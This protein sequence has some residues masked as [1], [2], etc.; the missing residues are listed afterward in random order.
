MPA[1]DSFF[2]DT[3]VLLYSVDATDAAKQLAAREWLAVLWT[4]GAG[5]LSWQVLH[6][7]YANAIRKLRTPS[8]KVRATV[9]I[10]NTWQPIEMSF[11]LIQRAWYWMDTAQLSYWD[12]MI[13]AAAERAGSRWLL[14]ED[15]QEGQK[16]GA[17]TIVNPLRSSPL[18]FGLRPQP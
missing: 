11:G 14:T 6:E 1:D 10:F 4:L 2:V 16:L 7:F 8:T 13:V 12:S 18:D 5:R 15:F 17:I 9:E 3:N